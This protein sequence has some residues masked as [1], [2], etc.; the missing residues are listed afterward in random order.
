MLPKAN[1]VLRKLESME[2]KLE[3][4]DNLEIFVKRQDERLREVSRKVERFVTIPDLVKEIDKGMT[5]LNGE[6]EILKRTFDEQRN[7]I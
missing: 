4:L 3:N 2:N 5:F 7:E 6:V 1:T